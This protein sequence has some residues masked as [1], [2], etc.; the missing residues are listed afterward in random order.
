[1]TIETRQQTLST[2]HGLLMVEESGHG[3]LPVLL[4]HGNSCCRSVFRHQ[5]QGPLAAEYRLIASDLPVPGQSS[6]PADPGRSYTTL[7]FADAAIEVLGQL[8]V[9]EAVVFGWSLGGHIGIEMM[10]RFPGLRGLIITGAPPVGRNEAAKGFIFSPHMAL[11]P[12]GR[13]LWGPVGG[14]APAGAG[15]EPGAPSRR[16]RGGG[17]DG[18]ARK[19]MFEAL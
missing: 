3:Q 13:F 12:P 1:M 2:S 8:G 6:K 15:G 19:T 17:A 10:S 16:A 5:L 9:A 4:I 14:V 11:A 7:G 18:L